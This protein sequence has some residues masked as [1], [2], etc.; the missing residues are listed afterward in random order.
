MSEKKADP[1]S[2]FITTAIIFILSMILGTGM[3]LSAKMLF[4]AITL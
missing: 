4:N 1:L 2:V 3:I